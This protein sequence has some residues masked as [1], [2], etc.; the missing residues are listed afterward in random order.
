MTNE[1]K[2]IAPAK[3]NLWL[4]I[5]NRRPDGYH[6]IESVMQTVTLHDTLTI[7]KAEKLSLS[8]SEPSLDCGEANLCCKAAR[9][10]FETTGIKGGAEIHI[11]KRIPVAGGLAG[12]STDA[13]ATLI[14]LNRIYNT[15][16]DR[17]ALCGMGVKIGA[18]VPF[19]IRQGIAVTRGIGERFADCP[20]LPACYIVISCAGEGI[21]TPWA[22]GRLDELYD[23]TSRNVNADEFV[24]VVKSGALEN[25]ADA[26]TNIFE[27][28]V[29]PVREKAVQLKEII[30]DGG[31]FRSMM[32]G[33]GPS[34]F[35][36]FNKKDLAEMT[37]RRLADL[38]I[39]AHLCEPYY[40]GEN[41]I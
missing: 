9:L 39:T 33:S 35:G 14:G 20:K 7:R 2:I 12:G 19:C 15:G 26:M 10:F 17:E 3:I 34:V 40:P 8:C 11:E 37:V 6:D 1:I 22:Y 21:S 38:G 18:D 31:A 28:V 24:E 25:I 27:T 16:Y 29:L 23:F 13:A 41:Q 4:E 30:R 5:K 36:I 32:S